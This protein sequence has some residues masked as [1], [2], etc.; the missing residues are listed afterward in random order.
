[1]CACFEDSGLKV[2]FLKLEVTLFNYYDENHQEKEV[3]DKFKAIWK[4]YN[5]D[6]KPQGNYLL[7]PAG[8]R[9]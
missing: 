8:E 6:M 2:T 3:M 1:M 5:W 9:K 7:I 4:E